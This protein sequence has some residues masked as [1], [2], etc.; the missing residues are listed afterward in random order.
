MLNIF[1]QS[2]LIATG[3]GA[4]RDEEIRLQRPKRVS[5]IKD[6]TSPSIRK[7]R[8]ERRFHADQAPPAMCRSRAAPAGRAGARPAQNGRPT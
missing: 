8:A 7:T 1:A 4:R 6:A 3:N 2:F 5:R